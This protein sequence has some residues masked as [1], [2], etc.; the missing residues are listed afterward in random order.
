MKKS[1]GRVFGA[2]LA[3]SVFLG[4][5]LTANAAGVPDNKI[6]IAVEFEKSEYFPGETATAYIKAEG[7]ADEADAG[8][9]LG[10]LEAGIKFD[11]TKL[12]FK[13]AEYLITSENAA[14]CTIAPSGAAVNSD[15]VTA[16]F[17]SGAGKELVKQSDGC[18]SIAKITFDV[19]EGAKGDAVVGI[20]DTYETMFVLPK[21]QQYVE[22]ECETAEDAKINITAYNYIIESKGATAADTIISDSVTVTKKNDSIQNAAL[23]AG[24]YEKD[25]KLLLSQA[26]IKNTGSDAQPFEIK[27]DKPT[28]PSG[29]KLEIRYYLWNSTAIASPLVPKKLVDVK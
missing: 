5:T 12:G 3:V 2:L 24:L 11:N 10:Q 14:D 6:K 21:G 16:L 9:K 13:S 7:I 20:D 29:T 27:F 8:Y 19:I 28:V 22:V 18:V 23:I 4:G 15:T 25:G 17:Y 1:I 26:V